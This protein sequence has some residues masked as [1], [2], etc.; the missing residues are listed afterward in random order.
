MVA[1]CKANPHE[2][3]VAAFKRT[4]PTFVAGESR[5]GGTDELQVQRRSSIHLGRGSANSS[6][7]SGSSAGG[8]DTD[9]DGG[10][11][12]D[13]GGEGKDNDASGGGGDGRARAYAEEDEEQQDEPDMTFEMAPARTMGGGGFGESKTEMSGDEDESEDEDEDKDEDED[14]DE[15]DGGLDDQ[16]TATA[17]GGEMQPAVLE[18]AARERLEQKYRRAP[19][20]PLAITIDGTAGAQDKVM[21]TYTLVQSRRFNGYPLY[22]M[23]IDESAVEPGDDKYATMYRSKDGGQGQGRW[24]ITRRYQV[25]PFALALIIG[26]VPSPAPE[27]TSS[28]LPL[29]HTIG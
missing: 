19:K 29:T 9:S 3:W 2:P 15:E 10:D 5:F 4:L 25:A 17:T 22:R 20:A 6:R 21:G 11:G 27:S 14:E 28:L 1:V 12:G 16:S 24:R 13:G 23:K 26:T 7:R 18:E 8:R